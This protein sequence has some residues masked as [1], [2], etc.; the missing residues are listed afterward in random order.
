MAVRLLRCPARPV[1]VPEHV[2]CRSQRREAGRVLRRSAQPPSATLSVQGADAGRDVLWNGRWYSEEAGRRE[3]ASSVAETED[4]PRTVLPRLSA[5]S[6]C[7]LLITI[8]TWS[9]CV[10]TVMWLV[11]TTKLA[12]PLNNFRVLTPFRPRLSACLLSSSHGNDQLRPMRRVL[13]HHP[14]R[15]LLKPAG[16]VQAEAE[17]QSAAHPQVSAAYGSNSSATRNVP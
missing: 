6:I 2:G 8:S 7:E 13:H 9:P 5:I 11:L 12:C 15:S 14:D 4:K 17:V 3:V 16:T 10:L 1:A